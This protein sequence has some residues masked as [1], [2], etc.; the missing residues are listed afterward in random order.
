MLQD[1]AGHH[2]GMDGPLSP[3]ISQPTFNSVI[4]FWGTTS[5]ILVGCL[6]VF[7]RLLRYTQRKRIL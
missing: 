4:G 5:L 6:V 1:A 7:L 3:P 2:T